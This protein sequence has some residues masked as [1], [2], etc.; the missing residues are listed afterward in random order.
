MRVFAH[1]ALPTALTLLL[2]LTL[3]LA[4]VTPAFAKDISFTYLDA[5]AQHTEPDVGDGNT[6]YRVEGSLG[7]LLGFYAF[8]RYE[9]AD[10]DGIDAGDFEATDLGLGWH[11]G[12]GD[13]I[14]GLAELSYSD[15]EVG[16]FDADGYT[17]A[18]GVRFAP[19]E[20]WEFGV[21][22][23]YR[24]LDRALDGG[25]GEGYVLWKVWGPLGVT[26]RA[27]LAEEANRFGLGARFSF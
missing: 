25:Y 17:A 7:L 21:K 2:V 18:V 8:G 24:D 22:A 13:T 1:R 5:T 12:L 26:A 19:V 14:Q 27:E 6:G 4:S 23:G 16:P 15:R 11:I 3:C 9:S 20:R 10:I